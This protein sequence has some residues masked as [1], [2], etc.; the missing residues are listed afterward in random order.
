MGGHVL[1]EDMFYVIEEKA[2][3]RAYFTG[4]HVSL[5]D[6]SYRRTFLVGQHVLLEDMSNREH[7]LLK[8]MSCW[9][10]CLTWNMS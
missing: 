7:V 5:E 9:G 1:K 10:T 3:R 8:D 6:L 4:R 2:Y